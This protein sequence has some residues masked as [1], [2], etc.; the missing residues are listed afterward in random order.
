MIGIPLHACHKCHETITTRDGLSILPAVN[1][2]RRGIVAGN[3]P[4][5]DLALSRESPVGTA[6]RRPWLVYSCIALY[7]NP[8]DLSWDITART[9]HIIYCSTKYFMINSGAVALL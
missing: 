1:L 5:L 4:L 8:P 7:F 3:N 2:F 6:D 9:S